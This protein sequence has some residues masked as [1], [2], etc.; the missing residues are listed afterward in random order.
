MEKKLPQSYFK[1][2]QTKMRVLEGDE[3]AVFI[4]RLA[5]DVNENIQKVPARQIYKLLH[6]LAMC[7]DQ[8]D[9]TTDLI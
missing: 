1:E 7:E 8:N 5:A 4:N 3:R 6:S 9:L 2:I